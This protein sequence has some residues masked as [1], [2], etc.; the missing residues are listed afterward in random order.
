MKGESVREI[1]FFGDCGPIISIHRTLRVPEVK[2][3]RA[4]FNRPPDFGPFEL[5]AVLDYAD[6]LPPEVVSKGDNKNYFVGMY[7]ES[8][9]PAEGSGSQTRE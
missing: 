8:E 3:R 2:D 6:K 9:H 5:F 4:V 7:G 1:Q